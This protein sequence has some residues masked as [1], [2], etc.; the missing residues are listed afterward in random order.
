MSLHRRKCFFWTKGIHSST[1]H[2]VYRHSLDNITNIPLD[3][4]Q[5]Q[6]LILVG[7]SSLTILP[8][9]FE[10]SPGN[11]Q[12]SSLVSSCQLR[13]YVLHKIKEKF[14]SIHPDPYS[15]DRTASNNSPPPGPEGWF[16]Q[17]VLRRG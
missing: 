14:I 10:I 16:C 2:T 17:R 11:K 15:R 4:E 7:Y 5:I 12:Y 1:L 8:Q 9:I 3:T 6:I 13:N